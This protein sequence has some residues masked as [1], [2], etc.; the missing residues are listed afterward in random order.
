[1]ILTYGTSTKQS[2]RATLKPTMKLNTEY[3]Y[4]GICIRISDIK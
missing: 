3:E 4:A 2:T 1:M